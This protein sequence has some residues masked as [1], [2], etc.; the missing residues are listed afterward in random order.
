MPG[1]ISTT[2]R[3]VLVEDTRLTPGVSGVAA[4]VATSASAVTG[5]DPAKDTVHPEAASAA[6]ATPSADRVLQLEDSED[7]CRT[8]I[9]SSARVD[10]KMPV[11]GD[12]KE[13]G[14]DTADATAEG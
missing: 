12:T 9:R 13:E 8:D 6:A 7:N 5:E 11:P 3:V 1:D 10:T 4:A 2:D 14:T